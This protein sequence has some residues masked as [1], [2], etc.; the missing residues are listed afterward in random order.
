MK[1]HSSKIKKDQTV[2]PENAPK[3]TIQSFAPKRLEVR[4]REIEEDTA[5]LME[6]E[7]R[8]AEV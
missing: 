3:A 4:K 8:L 1:K 5:K 6:L 7:A 2:P